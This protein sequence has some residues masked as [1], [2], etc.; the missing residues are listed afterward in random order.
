MENEHDAAA[1]AEGKMDENETSEERE[2]GKT[3]VGKDDR[4]YY[5]YCHDS[6]WFRERRARD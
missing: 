4:T 2:E 6:P 5:K 1:E 3:S